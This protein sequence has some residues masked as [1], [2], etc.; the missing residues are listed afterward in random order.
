[1]K[2]SDQ[3]FTE[4]LSSQAS[5]AGSTNDAAQ[6][7]SVSSKQQSGSSDLLQLSS[8][9][10]RL[11]NASSGDAAASRASRVSQ[12]SQIVNSG[13]FRIDPSKISSALISEA[14]QPSSR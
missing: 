12:L 14:V 4:R 9:A 6:G 11:Q 1:M 13:N 3:G 8:I 2:I 10:S 7:N 5:R